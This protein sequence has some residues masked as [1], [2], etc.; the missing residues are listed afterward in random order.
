MNFLLVAVEPGLLYFY[1]DVC[2]VLCSFHLFGSTSATHHL[3]RNSQDTEIFSVFCFTVID[4]RVW[5][6]HL[7]RYDILMERVVGN[8]ELRSVVPIIK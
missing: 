6:V 1:Y 5:E 2:R 4:L 3:L 7:N 8:W